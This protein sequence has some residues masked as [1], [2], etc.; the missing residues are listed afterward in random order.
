VAPGQSCLEGAAHEALIGAGKC[1]LLLQKTAILLDTAVPAASF[2][3]ERLPQTAIGDA[4][5][6][7]ASVDALV[8]NR[9]A[10]LLLAA[11][12]HRGRDRDL[13]AEQAE[14]NQEG[15]EKRINRHL[16][17]PI[18]ITLHVGSFQQFTR[19]M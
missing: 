18:D 14:T 10:G 12:S 15:N 17:V 16:H 3:A 4:G 13:D 1:G 9:N 5:R 7:R 2:H 8:A 19:L 6:Y 11:A